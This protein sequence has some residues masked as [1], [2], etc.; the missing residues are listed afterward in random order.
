MKHKILRIL[1][2]LLLVCLIILLNFKYK[3]NYKSNI[4]NTPIKKPEPAVI[5]EKI[6]IDELR[7]QYNNND[8]IAYI[9]IPEVIG[10][11]VMQG[12]DNDYYLRHNFLKEVSSEGWP[13]ADYRNKFDGTDK[14]IIIYIRDK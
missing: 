5:E 9:E 1:T 2:I 12:E 10:T 11:I 6:K 7:K 8:I 14:N 13:F 3:D 4:N